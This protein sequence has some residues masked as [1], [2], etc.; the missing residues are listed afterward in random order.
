MQLNDLNLDRNLYK[1]ALGAQT[2]DSALISATNADNPISPIASGNAATDVNWGSVTIDGGQLTPGT[3]PQTVLDVGNWGWTQTCVFTVLDADTIQ[4]GAGTFTSADGTTV[5]AISAG[6]TGNM[7]AITYVYMDLAF[8]TAYQIT[9]NVDTP[10]GIG[11]V[12]IAVCQNGGTTA[13]FN[14]VQAHQIVGDNIL[15]NTIDASKITAGQ[16]VVGTNVG[17]G[18]AQTS[19]NVTTI[20]GNTVTTGFINALSITAGS[21]AA[22]NITGTTM[23]GKTVQTASSGI[24]VVLGP[25]GYSD[26]IQ[27][28]NSST[29]YGAIYTQS[30]SGGG[31]VV[32]DTS[33]GS[34]GAAVS[35]Q[36][37]SF[38]MAAV[39]YNGAGVYVDY[40]GVSIVNAGF[41]PSVN[42]NQDLGTSALRWINIWATGQISG[43]SLVLT[44]TIS[45]STKSNFL[46]SVFA[47][48]LPT[49]LDS[50]DVIRRIPEPVQVGE[51]GHYGDGLYFDDLT[52]PEE[53][54]WELDGKME[55]EH[56][57]MI[58]LLMQAVR[59]LTK[60]VDDLE[61]L[62]N[63]P[64]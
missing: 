2:F 60:K 7:A 28:M 14:L 16:L 22:E 50:L 48:P 26:R 31:T 37:G 63:K 6:N 54:L 32:M 61:L 39:T 27:F 20:I 35:V 51:R 30:Y 29:V 47:C 15:A 58:G 53:A 13:T 3:F 40:S 33:D 19:G 21:V 56:T 36:Y 8:P 11:K 57:H 44:G 17:L 43:G 5:L 42:N 62:I 25:S 12:L 9:T 34:S 59:Q 24:R 38:P 4:W 49:I 18:T 10:I 64:V 41:F 46:G 23:T 45:N 55:I 1:N 52:F